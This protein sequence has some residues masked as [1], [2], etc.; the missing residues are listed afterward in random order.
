ML[1]GA[2]L[3]GA[4]RVFRGYCRGRL[5]VWEALLVELEPGA[6]LFH[7]ALVWATARARAR[8]RLAVSTA[9]GNCASLGVSRGQ[10]VEIT[11]IL[12]A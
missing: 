10:R 5:M 2:V 1:W 12:S 8:A 4:F 6:N 11:W 9:S 3:V 7:M